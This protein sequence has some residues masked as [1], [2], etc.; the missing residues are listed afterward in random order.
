MTR[1]VEEIYVNATLTLRKKSPKWK[2]P[3]MKNSRSEEGL[4]APLNAIMWKD[5]KWEW[6]NQGRPPTLPGHKLAI[7]SLIL[8]QS[9]RIVVAEDCKWVSSIRNAR[10]AVKMAARSRSEHALCKIAALLVLFFNQLSSRMLL[11]WDISIRQV[12]KIPFL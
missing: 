2:T 10:N 1:D 11:V 3:G 12:S 9:W 8:S 4:T 5:L 6:A 7:K